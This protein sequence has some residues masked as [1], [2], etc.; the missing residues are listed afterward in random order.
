M[1][2]FICSGLPRSRGDRPQL[3][4]G[5]YALSAAPPLTRGSTLAIERGDGG[6][7]GSPA[8]AGIDRPLACERAGVYRLPRSRGDRP[9]MSF[10]GCRN[11]QAPPL[12]RGST[13]SIPTGEA[14]RLGSP[15]H[16][17][18]DPDCFRARSSAPGLPRSRGDRPHS[19]GDRRRDLTAPPLTR[20]STRVP[21]VLTIQSKGSPAHAG[22]DRYAFQLSG[23]PC[24]LPR[25]RGDRPGARKRC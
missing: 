15:A 24:W 23:H 4:S 8:H 6:G 19:R 2:I 7:E 25:S 10:I 12:T 22:I 20:G 14:F 9:G 18:I 17:G 21:R 1:T 13:H 11:L 16:A 3:G 5:Y